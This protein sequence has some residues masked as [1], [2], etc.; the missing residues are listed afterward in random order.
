MPFALTAERCNLFYKTW[1]PIINDQ[2]L[3]TKLVL[4][5]Q[6]SYQFEN[7]PENEVFEI[8]VLRSG[9]ELARWEDMMINPGG[10]DPATWHVFGGHF[11]PVPFFGRF[12]Q[13]EQI[14][15]RIKALGPEAAD[16][17]FPRIETDPLNATIRVVIR[18]WQATML[19][20]RNGAPRPVD[21]GVQLDNYGKVI[22]DPAY[23]D[24]AYRLM[25]QFVDTHNGGG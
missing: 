14:T 10:A 11:I 18:G 16:G 15:V 24:A 2:V 12:D 20:R 21:P 17:T 8:S 7:L 9:I 4:I 23:M 13:S 6:I 22:I 25:Q 1:F 5:D 19:D 3:D